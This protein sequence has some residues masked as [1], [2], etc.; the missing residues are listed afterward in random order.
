MELINTR[1][2]ELNSERTKFIDKVALGYKS[3]L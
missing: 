3:L 1:V 2:L